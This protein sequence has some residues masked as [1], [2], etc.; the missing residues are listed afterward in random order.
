[1]KSFGIIASRINSPRTLVSVAS[2]K[3]IKAFF[4]VFL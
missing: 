1:M 2:Y 4:V 3:R